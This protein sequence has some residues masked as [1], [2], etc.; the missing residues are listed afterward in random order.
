MKKSSILL[1]LKAALLACLVLALLPAHAA[2]SATAPATEPLLRIEAGMHAAMI[3][4]IATDAAGR[5]AVTASDDKTARVWDVASGKL[6]RV[7]RPPIGPGNGGKLFAV[8][9]SPDGAV[10]A[11]AG[12]TVSGTTSGHTVYLF[13]R[14]SG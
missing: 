7:L 1:S 2:Q 8:A 10:V 11:A 6:Q 3:K 12:W 5:W 14:S 4:R 9:I 13:D